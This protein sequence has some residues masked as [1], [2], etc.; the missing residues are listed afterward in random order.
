VTSDFL[1]G[2]PTGFGT[3]ICDPICGAF[4]DRVVDGDNDVA[5]LVAELRSMQSSVRPWRRSLRSTVRA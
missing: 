3:F 2:V 5:M 1:Q 4:L